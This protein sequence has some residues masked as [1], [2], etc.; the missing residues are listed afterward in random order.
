MNYLFIITI[1]VAIFFI[2]Q[3]LLSRKEKKKEKER[4][5]EI[6]D[7]RK[8]YNYSNTDYNDYNDRGY[9]NYYKKEK[10]Y[11]KEIYTKEQLEQQKKFYKLKEISDLRFEQL[12]KISKTDPDRSNLVNELNVIRNK[13]KIIFPKTGLKMIKTKN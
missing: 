12:Q 8:K 3:F 7:N 5:K 10:I 11:T 1:V 9:D 6:D 2:V 4:K 13:M